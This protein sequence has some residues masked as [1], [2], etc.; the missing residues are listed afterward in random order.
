MTT[1]T[2]QPKQSPLALTPETM[3]EL[4]RKSGSTTATADAIRQMIQ[5][6]APTNQ[7]GSIHVIKFTAYLVK[8][9][10]HGK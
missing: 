4:L 2:P 5:D 6:G 8:R 10:Q 9:Y 3:A 1:N 7:D